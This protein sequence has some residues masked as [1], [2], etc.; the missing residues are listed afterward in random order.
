MR[1]TRAFRSGGGSD[2]EE[3]IA[4]PCI[5]Q[6]SEPVLTLQTATD[7]TTGKQLPSLKLTNL[8]FGDVAV[9]LTLLLLG[10]SKNVVAAADGLACTA[11]CAFGSANEGKYTFTAVAPGYQPKAYAVDAVFASRA[12]SCP[13]ML[14]N[15]SKLDVA[16]VPG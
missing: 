6:S 3:L 5:I 2:S 1:W 8:K 7:A 10:A 11:P 12:G 16:L 15:G 13:L 9:D 14:S 4:G